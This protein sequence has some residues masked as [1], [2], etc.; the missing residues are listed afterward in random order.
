LSDASS[1]KFSGSSGCGCTRV[2][3]PCS[4]SLQGGVVEPHVRPCSCMLRALDSPAGQPRV[5]TD[6]HPRR[7]GGGAVPRSHLQAARAGL[8]AR[9]QHGTGYVR[10]RHQLRARRCVARPRAAHLHR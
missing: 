9:D 5:G 6:R 1:V 3:V 7:L 4:P 2:Q 10:S 8:A